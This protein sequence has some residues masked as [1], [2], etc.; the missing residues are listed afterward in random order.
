MVVSKFW[1]CCSGAPRKKVRSLLV[2]GVF[3]GTYTFCF[4]LSSIYVVYGINGSHRLPERASWES[5]TSWIIRRLK[6]SPSGIVYER[7]LQ[8]GREVT[9]LGGRKI[10]IIVVCWCVFWGLPTLGEYHMVCVT[11]LPDECMHESG[12]LGCLWCSRL[13]FRV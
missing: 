12:S 6:G 9:F 13:G 5:Y 4:N 3:E 1:G 10:I 11:G 8:L 7:F 2:S